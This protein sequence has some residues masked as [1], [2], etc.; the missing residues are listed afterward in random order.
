MTRERNGCHINRGSL[1]KSQAHHK[2]PIPTAAA[3]GIRIM[4][5][6]IVLGTL[7]TPSLL[8]RCCTCRTSVTRSASET[9][10]SFVSRQ[11]VDV[12]EDRPNANGIGTRQLSMS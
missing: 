1:G 12:F 10:S 3:I 4:I 5:R 2:I 7:F 11:I 8:A 6:L 9:F